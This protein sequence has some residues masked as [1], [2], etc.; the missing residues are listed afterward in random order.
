MPVLRMLL[1][2]SFVL[3]HLGCAGSTP[4]DI[5]YHAELTSIPSDVE[6]VEAGGEEE[7][8]GRTPL[9]IDGELEIEGRRSKASWVVMSLGAA[10]TTGLAVQAVRSNEGRNQVIVPIGWGVVPAL[11][12]W[13]FSRQLDYLTISERSPS[14]Q[15][16]VVVDRRH[17]KPSDQEFLDAL[18]P[19]RYQLSAPG[20]ETT[21]VRAQVG[22]LTSV[23][24]PRSDGAVAT[25]SGGGESTSALIS[26]LIQGV[27]QSNAYALVVGIE[28]YRSVMP[29]PGARRDAEEFA[30]LLEVSFG[31]PEQNIHLLTDE[32]ATRT[33][34]LSR[35]QWL[36][37][38]VPPNG[39]VYFFFSGHGSPDVESGES[40]LLPYE[41]QPETLALSGIPVHAVLD[42][43]QSTEASEVLAFVDACFS[44]SGDRSTLPEGTRPLVPVRDVETTSLT[45][46]ALFSS[47]SATEISG[48]AAD[49]ERGLFTHYLLEAVGNGAADIDG[50]GQISL[51]EL[52]QYVTPRVAR[53]ARRMD[54]NQNPTLLLSDDLGDPSQVILLWGL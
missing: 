21:L 37:N 3:I 10:M 11:A 33:D 29:T 47:S 8:I 22:Q 40:N 36:Q 31:V 38:N 54:R 14:L 41:G 50:N 52:A 4:S 53:D 12:T 5:R 44:G 26:D 13:H 6:V 23:E 35:L 9:V 51:D 46:V 16:N 39:R 18:G 42:H 49:E 45:K 7:F 27:P 30:Q 17:R 24:L 1:A 48:N 34:I 15:H 19:I 25:T 28:D 32:N 43:L 20:Y 2:L